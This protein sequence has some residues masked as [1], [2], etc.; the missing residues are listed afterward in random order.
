MSEYAARHVSD[1]VD[2]VGNALSWLYLASTLAN[3]KTLEPNAKWIND[4]ARSEVCEEYDEF[5]PR[6]PRHLST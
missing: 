2:T 6:L 4:L 3:G 1:E 5:E